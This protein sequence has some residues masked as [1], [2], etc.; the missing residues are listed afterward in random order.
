M[1]T[2]WLAVIAVFAAMTIGLSDAEARRA[3]GG[4]S[5]GK[6][7]PVQRQ[8][9]PPQQQAPAAAPNAAQT[10]QAGAAA[11]PGAAAAAPA[12][13][14]SRWMGPIA[15][16]AAGLGLAALASYL[17]FGEELASILMMVLLAVVALVVIRLVMAR[18]AGGQPR[19]AFAAGGPS[20]AN[21]EYRGAPE[22]WSM[23]RQAPSA[24]GGASAAPAMAAPTAAGPVD[25]GVQVPAEFDTAGFIHNAKVYFVRLQA[26]FDAEDKQDLR[27]FTSPEMFAELRLQIDARKGERS[28]TD[29][30]TLDA[31]IVGFQQDDHEYLVSVLFSGLIR[32]AIDSEAKPFEEVWN[33]TKPVAAKGGWVLSGIQQLAA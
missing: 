19:P 16:I 1:K 30:I 18:R 17:G 8:A 23:P 13:A 9:T 11:R 27:E 29:V 22:S 28:Q 4:M 33:L 5:I 2:F 25:A 15:G 7:A 21:T 24:I 32:E 6:Q 20:G 14:G 10:P 26:A 31:T 12:A 3:G